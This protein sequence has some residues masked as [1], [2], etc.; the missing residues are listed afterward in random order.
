MS[1]K[2]QRVLNTALFWAPAASMKKKPCW[3]SLG[4]YFRGLPVRLAS[5]PGVIWEFRVFEATSSSGSS[6]GRLALTR[7][8]WICDS[9]C[10]RRVPGLTL[11]WVG[12]RPPYNFHPH[13]YSET[14]QRRRLFVNTTPN[15]HLLSFTFLDIH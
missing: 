5:P 9:I 12:V 6:V 15:C 8:T 2:I 13:V 3:A 14:A 4:S 1:I 7:S 11:M 10:R